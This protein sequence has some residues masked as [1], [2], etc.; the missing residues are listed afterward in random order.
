MTA[1]ADRRINTAE[2]C[3]VYHRH[4]EGR[5]LAYA[6][7]SAHR[8]NERLAVV[9]LGCLLRLDLPQALVA[10]SYVH[11]LMEARRIQRSQRLPDARD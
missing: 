10:I 3:D 9:E 7:L 1:G 5:K 4:V 11:L 2:G 6:A 8:W